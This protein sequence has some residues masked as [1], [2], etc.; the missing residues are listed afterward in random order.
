MEDY[1]ERKYLSSI[2]AAMYLNTTVSTIHHLAKS[3]E[4]NSVISGSGQKGDCVSGQDWRHRYRSQNE[5]EAQN[6]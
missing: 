4:I 3:G 5:K 2:E 1:K 6:V